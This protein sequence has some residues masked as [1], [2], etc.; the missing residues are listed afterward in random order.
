MKHFQAWPFLVSRNKY[1]D[2]RTIVAPDFICKAKSASLLAKVAEGD[3][4]E[5]NNLLYR[6][7]YNSKVGNIT[8]VFRVIE[9]KAEDI[10]IE[11]SG[12]LKDSFGREILFLEGLVFKN[13]V[14]EIIVTKNYFF[15]IHKQLVKSY[16]DFWDCETFSSISSKKMTISSSNLLDD[17]FKYKKIKRYDVKFT[18]KII[19]PT[20]RHKN[21]YQNK[22]VLNDIVTSVL[23][24]PNGE[25][26]ILRSGNN[27]TIVNSNTL[28]TINQFSGQ[29][30]V[31][32][33]YLYPVAVDS[34]GTLIVSS[35]IKTPEQNIVKLWNI[36]SD[37]KVE[38]G[39]HKFSWNHRIKAVAFSPN[40]KTVVSA[41]GD[42]VIKLWDVY[43]S[44]EI[45]ELN[46]HQ[47]E[48]RSL[49]LSKDG[50]ILVSADGHGVINFWNL[51]SQQLKFSSPVYNKPINSLA[52]SPNNQ[53][54]ASGGDDYEVALWDIKTKAKLVIGSHK[55]EVNSVVFNRDG[56]LLA[57][58]SNDR[59]IK[60]WD[61]KNQ[62]EI[63]TLSEDTGEVTSLAFN[64]NGKI[65]ASGSKDKTI[66]LWAL[67]IN[68]N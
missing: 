56:S 57:S 15:E 4:T 64:P 48:V 39:S 46:G 34:T 10:G 21:K 32:G 58:G 6:E 52:F 29:K 66:K 31:S 24:L 33:H 59:T 45:G 13:I 35:F 16:Y 18:K 63:C 47:S 53:K 1:L 43:G 51:K 41:G 62:K 26:L 11:G 9:A 20:Q 44:G 55:G 28:K 36:K 14:P 2:Y 3:L 12:I 50:K 54:I 67:M 40:N 8:I 23:F 61:I 38:L 19:N 22:L 37:E 68:N 17:K 5:P 7:I 60:I 25:S 27:I 30:V 42:K 49:A 65:L